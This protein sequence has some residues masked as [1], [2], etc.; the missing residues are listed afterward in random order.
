MNIRKLVAKLRRIANANASKYLIGL[1]LKA[2]QK[3][4][5]EHIE[6]PR[7]FYNGLQEKAR[8]GPLF[9]ENTI[10]FFEQLTLDDEE[11]D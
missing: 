10:R 7:E 5:P 8:S 3:D 2:L 9:D 11:D 6:N 1:N 4:K